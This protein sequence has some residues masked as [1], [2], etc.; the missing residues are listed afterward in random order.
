ML[1]VKKG[2]CGLTA[3]NNLYN[4]ALITTPKNIAQEALTFYE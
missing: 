4:K 1:N 3:R 2:L